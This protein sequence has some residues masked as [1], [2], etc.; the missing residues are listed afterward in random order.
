LF[1]P[2]A[3]ALACSHAPPETEP[4]LPPSPVP[5]TRTAASSWQVPSWVGSDTYRFSLHAVVTSDSVR[6]KAFVFDTAGNETFA[7]RVTTRSTTFTLSGS[8]GARPG[9]TSSATLVDGR[10]VVAKQS[11]GF[12]QCDAS[13]NQLR[14]DLFDL[15]VQVPSTLTLQM[16]WTDSTSADL[17]VGGVPG[18]A[19]SIRRYTVVGDTAFNDGLAV[20]VSRR[21]STTAAAEGILEQHPTA[22]TGTATANVLLY[23]SESSGKVVRITKEQI[24]LLSVTAEGSTRAFVQKLSGVVDLVR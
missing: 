7:H 15:G 11:G 12:P 24:L 21:D 10:L 1:S 17:C 6:E 2:L 14:S 20:I 23:V 3:F 8:D 9:R 16:A 18:S 19:R 4:T 13:G 5:H 22:I